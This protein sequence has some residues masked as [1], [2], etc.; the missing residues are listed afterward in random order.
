MKPYLHRF[1]VL[2]FALGS[3][4]FLAPAIAQERPFNL[5]DAIATALQ[6][7]PRPN[8]NNER[9][10]ALLEKVEAEKASAYPKA[11][12]SSNHIV[13]QNHYSRYGNYRDS[14]RELTIG[15]TVNLFNNNADKFKEQAAQCEHDR[16]KAE[17]NS[18][19]TQKLNTQGQLAGLVLRNYLEII[20][21]QEIIQFEQKV[22]TILG[23]YLNAATNDEERARIKQFADSFVID[24]AN[25]NFK[26]TIELQ[27]FEYLT[28][29]PAPPVFETMDETISRIIVPSSLAEANEIA[30]SKSPEVLTA[31]L[32]IRCNQLQLEYDKR[33]QNGPRVDFE[34]Y[35][36]LGRYRQIGKLDHLRNTGAK[37]SLSM[38]YGASD[39]KRNKS[40]LHDIEASREDLKGAIR[41]IANDLG[42]F[43][44]SNNNLI[45][46]IRSYS[47]SEAESIGSIQDV[48]RKIEQNQPIDIAYALEL[49]RNLDRTQAQL[50]RSK[51]DLINN[52]FQIQKRIGT[53]F[54]NLNIHGLE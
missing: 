18:T 27:Q 21:F 45:E 36:G 12:I 11:Y 38:S 30:L 14:V 41:D 39:E 47:R 9:L 19:N 31:Q 50:M 16:S 28:T 3:F 51:Q 49:V 8:A 40:Q 37:I 1:F 23:K 52:K 35:H 44:P 17:Y 26:K 13:E 2:F 53:L 34:V 20:Q 10:K 24:L 15:A 29:I 46:I 43:Y 4:Y 42:R 54:D 5:I 33:T 48:L 6:K 7:N 32:Q 22:L 25:M